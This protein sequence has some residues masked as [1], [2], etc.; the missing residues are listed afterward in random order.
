MIVLTPINIR[1]KDHEPCK[2]DP[3]LP[4]PL[5]HQSITFA[6]VDAPYGMLLGMPFEK[7]VDLRFFVFNSCC[8]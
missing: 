7:V 2:R 4:F 5:L 8:I 6:F 1:H 3:G